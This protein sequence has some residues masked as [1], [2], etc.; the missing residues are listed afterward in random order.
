[1]Q[2]GLIAFNAISKNKLISTRYME[3][4]HFISDICFRLV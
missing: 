4:A 2:S 1:M 3:I